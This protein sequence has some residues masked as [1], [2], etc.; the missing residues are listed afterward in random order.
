MKVLTSS[1]VVW[2]RAT[3]KVWKPVKPTTDQRVKKQIRTSRTVS[4]SVKEHKHPDG[5]YLTTSADPTFTHI[6]SREVGG[7]TIE[8][9]IPQCSP[10]NGVARTGLGGALGNCCVKILEECNP[11]KN[12]IIC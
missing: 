10:G 7:H 1:L 8:V 6:R 12:R 9:S 4:S 11:I 3:R 2:L 5:G